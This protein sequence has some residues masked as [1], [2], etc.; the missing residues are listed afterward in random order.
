MTIPAWVAVGAEAVVLSHGTRGL[1]LRPFTVTRFTQKTVWATPDGM[2]FGARRFH[3]ERNGRLTEYGF[4]DKTIAPVL[5]ER[6][7]DLSIQMELLSS[8]AQSVN[9]AKLF[10]IARNTDNA[11]HLIEA[12]NRYVESEEEEFDYMSEHTQYQEIEDGEEQ[13]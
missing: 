11:K 3:L 13:K 12:L 9:M 6:T 10:L 1:D 5:V 4:V 7:L 2:N 8:K